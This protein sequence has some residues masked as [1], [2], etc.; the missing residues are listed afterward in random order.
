[1]PTTTPGSLNAFFALNQHPIKINWDTPYVM[2]GINTKIY[3]VSLAKDNSPL[4]I[5]YMSELHQGK[6]KKPNEIKFFAPALQ[7]FKIRRS[8]DSELFIALENII[9]SFEFDVQ[10]R[11]ERGLMKQPKKIFTPV[12]YGNEH[13]KF[14]VPL[15]RLKIKIG[16]TEF[17]KLVSGKPEK[18]I[19]TNENIH[20]HITTFSEHDGILKM[21]VCE[22]NYGITLRAEV[23]VN[24][25]S[26]TLIRPRLTDLY[27]NMD[28]E[29]RSVLALHNAYYDESKTNASSKETQT[30]CPSFN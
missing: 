28:V 11:V 1:M 27:A 9:D 15:A 18:I 22:H 3:T 23:V 30:Y 20:E 8:G 2:P 19:V 26:R 5:K 4:Y 16:K 25:I 10:D 13:G 21:S 14:P 29:S 17:A 7:I 6:I 12:Q 24:C